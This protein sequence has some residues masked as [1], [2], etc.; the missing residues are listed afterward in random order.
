MAGHSA[1][2]SGLAHV[3]CGWIGQQAASRLTCGEVRH[4]EIMIWHYSKC[5]ADEPELLVLYNGRCPVCAAEVGHYARAADK[6]GLPI[7]FDDLNTDAL[8]RWGMDADTAARRL[9]VQH[10]GVL[11]SGV[12]AFRALW[13]GMPRYRWMARI[14]GLPGIRHIACA[15]YDHVFAPA[16]YRRHLRRLR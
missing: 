6:A 10:E 12:P 7:Q 16:L 13:S 3:V 2:Q 11:I 1:R 5:M 14:V 15:A 9:Y 4:A 8:S